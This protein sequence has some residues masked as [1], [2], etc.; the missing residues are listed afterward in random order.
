MCDK[1]EI[2]K[3]DLGYQWV[4]ETGFL[5]C[6]NSPEGFDSRAE[7]IESIGTINREGGGGLRRHI[8]VPPSERERSRWL[9]HILQPQPFEGN[10]YA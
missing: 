5:D 2:H 1:K 9:E 8:W 3:G 4:V 7:K 10:F 6:Y